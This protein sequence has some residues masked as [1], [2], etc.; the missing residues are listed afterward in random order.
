MEAVIFVGIQGS[1]KSTFYKARFFRTHVR[2]NLDMLRTRH[3]LDILLRACLEAKQPF[4]LDNTNVTIAERAP[5]IAIARAERFRVIGYYFDV[6]VAD[7]LRRNE[8]R[9]T[10]EHIPRR[11]LFGTLKRLEVPALSEGFDLLYTVRLGENG[12][13]IVT[14]GQGKSGAE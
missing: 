9:P 13:A 11:G 6:T 12:Q 1:G 10:E 14:D 4:V 8:A 5:Y 7:A 2:L 3:R